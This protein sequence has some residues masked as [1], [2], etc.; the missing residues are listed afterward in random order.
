MIANFG[1]EDF[2]CELVSVES[3]LSQFSADSTGQWQT[4]G[5]LVG[6]RTI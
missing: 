4:L 6:R 2:V 5:E 1:S 3:G